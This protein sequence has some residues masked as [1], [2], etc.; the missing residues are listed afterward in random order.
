MTQLKRAK[1]LI[2]FNPSYEHIA[3]K[4]KTKVGIAELAKETEALVSKEV[5]ESKMPKLKMAT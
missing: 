1:Q 4:L 3:K 2:D 5:I